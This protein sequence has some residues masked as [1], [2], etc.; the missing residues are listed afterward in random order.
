M[1]RNRWAARGFPVVRRT[2]ASPAASCAG[3][4]GTRA[5]IPASLPDLVQACLLQSPQPDGLV[6]AQ[7]GQSES[8]QLR[9]A[10]ATH[11]LEPWEEL[12]A[13]WQWAPVLSL[14]SRAPDSLIFTSEGIRIA[15]KRLRLH[16]PYSAFAGCRF[17][18]QF[19]PGGRTGPDV[20]RLCV[21]GPVP[22]RSPSAGQ[23]AE[24]IADDLNRVRELAAG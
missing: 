9:R 20:S 16:L 14:V 10:R 24:L 17:R 22:W 1:T 11:R 5:G 6:V 4:A 3:S 15:E 7:P 13:V 21:D 8:R 18:Y 19:T 12:I 23:G 2:A